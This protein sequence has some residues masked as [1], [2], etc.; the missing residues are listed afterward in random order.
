MKSERERFSSFDLTGVDRLEVFGDGPDSILKML[1]PPSGDSGG[2]WYGWHIL[3]CGR[4]SFRDLCLDGNRAAFV[5]SDEQTH[6]IQIRHSHDVDFLRVLAKDSR[7]DFCKI[8]GDI[9]D[10][11]LACDRLSFRHCKIENNLRGGILFQRLARRVHVSHCEFLGGNDCPIDFEPTGGAPASEIVLTNNRVQI[12]TPTAHA[13]TLANGHRLVVMDNEFIGGEMYGHN[14]KDAVIIGNRIIG[15]SR[16]S[17]AAVSIFRASRDVVI[18][19]NEIQTDGTG[20]AGIE[21]LYNNGEA[22]IHVDIC[23]NRITGKTGSNITGGSNYAIERNSIMDNGDKA[24]VGV[25]VAATNSMGVSDVLI[26]ENNIDG[27]AYC[28]QFASS[29]GPIV[30]A[31]MRDNSCTNWRL[32]ETRETGTHPR[33]IEVI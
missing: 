31:R 24:G 8:V 4:V 25:N 17:R 28:L 27:F 15:G 23:D 16:K 18:A 2:D 21:C 33:E 22:P 30:Y 6:L 1:P 11:S 32:A 20:G 7:G 19:D 26:A 13:I 9:G 5:K 14:V 29:R 10:D 12:D 3:D